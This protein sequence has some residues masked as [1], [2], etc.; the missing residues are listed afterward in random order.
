MLLKKT[1][2]PPTYFPRCMDNED[3]NNEYYVKIP[4]L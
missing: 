1:D 3:L 4:I 2:V